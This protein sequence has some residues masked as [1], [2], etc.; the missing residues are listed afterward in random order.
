MEIKYLNNSCKFKGTKNIKNVIYIIQRGKCKAGRIF[1]TLNKFV[2]VSAMRY[3]KGES[4]NIIF[5][6]KKN[7]D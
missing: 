4:E 6:F 3:K 1:M 5:L 2:L 7:R